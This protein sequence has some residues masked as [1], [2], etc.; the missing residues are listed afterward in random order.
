MK[1]KRG[2]QRKKEASKE[3]KRSI[4]HAY[5]WTVKLLEDVHSTVLVASV[6]YT[7]LLLTAVADTFFSPVSSSS[8]LFR[9]TF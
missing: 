1:K 2:K 4:M 7:F 8:V 6:L 3:K 9:F 5:L